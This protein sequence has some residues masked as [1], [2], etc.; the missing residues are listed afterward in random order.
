MS[1]KGNDETPTRHLRFDAK[2]LIGISSSQPSQLIEWNAFNGSSRHVL[3]GQTGEIV[4]LSLRSHLAASATD[5]LRLWDVDKGVCLHIFEP[6]LEFSMCLL[7]GERLLGGFQNTLSAWDVVSKH[8]LF[9]IT[10]CQLSLVFN[11]SIVACW[12][13]NPRVWKHNGDLINTFP[14]FQD[15]S[16]DISGNIYEGHVGGT[17]MA[18]SQCRF[19]GFKMFTTGE[20]PV[21]VH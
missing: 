1:Y 14:I 10:D 20:K 2:T 7:V 5:S 8:H 4:D 16:G 6:S 21:S 12:Y 17:R 13:G 9:T 18:V 15:I 3:R 19:K 11:D